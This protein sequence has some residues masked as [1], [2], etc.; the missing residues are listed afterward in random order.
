MGQNGEMRWVGGIFAL[1]GSVL[2]LLSSD[3]GIGQYRALLEEE[4]PRAVAPTTSVS[5]V[6][7]TCLD[8]HHRH[9]HSESVSSTPAQPLR[10]NGTTTSIRRAPEILQDV[11]HARRLGCSPTCLRNTSTILQVDCPTPR[12]ASSPANHLQESHV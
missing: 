12:S 1:F 6:D 2:G 11:F 8:N 4:R 5:F 7:A 9:A 3:S 10:L